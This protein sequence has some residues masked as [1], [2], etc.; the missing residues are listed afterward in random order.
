MNVA[1]LTSAIKGVVD[2]ASF[3]DSE[4]LE[5][6]NAGLLDIAGGGERVHGHAKIAPLPDLLT[7]WDLEVSSYKTQMPSDYHRSVKGV[8]NGNTA[9]TKHDSFV[10]MNR[11]SLAFSRT[12]TPEEYIMQG[13]YLY[14]S[15]VPTS[16]TFRITGYKLP[17][18][19]VEDDDE[20]DCLPVHL[21]KRLLVNYAAKEIFSIIEQGLEGAMPGTA[22]HNNFYQSALTD[23]ERF[24]GPEDDEPLFIYDDGDYIR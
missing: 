18:V 8:F 22:K 3:T 23:L 13:N 20:P 1:E 6:L 17:T 19:L 24:I 10:R 21:Q 11:E 2:D 16:A 7:V 4:I 15:P 12:G 14:C 9:L 5:L